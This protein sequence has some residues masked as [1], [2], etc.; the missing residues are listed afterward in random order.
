MYDG[1]RFGVRIGNRSRT[2]IDVNLL[3]VDSSYQI[4]PLFPSRA[5]MTDNRLL[6]G[7][8]I[9]VPR[10][11]AR[12]T[13]ETVGREYLVFLATPAPDQPGLPANFAFLAQPGVS[14]GNAFAIN[15][16]N[17]NLLGRG[18]VGLLLQN[19]LFGV[20]GRRGGVVVYENEFELDIRLIPW[21]T[22]D[23]TRPR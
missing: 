21:L 19:A 9:K 5:G 3:F 8:E 6:P 7:Q 12:V 23:G 15:R 20:G 10:R 18:Q 22:V 11:R 2:A 14:Q 13:R 17:A 16:G 4:V 1:D